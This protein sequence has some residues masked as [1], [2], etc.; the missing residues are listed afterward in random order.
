MT[1]S[2]PLQQQLIDFHDYAKQK[3]VIICPNSAG[4]GGIPD[5]G[6]FYTAE[7]LKKTSDAEI[8]KMHM[9]LYGNGGAPSVSD[10]PGFECICLSHTLSYIIFRR[11][12]SKML[13]MMNLND[14]GRN[15][16]HACCNDCGN[17]SRA[18]T[19]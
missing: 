2:S 9:F 3:K 15:T 19:C 17:G 11:Q 16:R 1:L 4:A 14:A 13:T 18:F 7:E 5:I 8:Q 6:A 10:A 12:N